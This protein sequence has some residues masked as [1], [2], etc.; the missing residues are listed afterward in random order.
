[1]T[2]PVSITELIVVLR[3]IACTQSCFTVRHAAFNRDRVYFC[4][5]GCCHDRAVVCTVRAEQLF[6]RIGGQ[7]NKII[8]QLTKSRTTKNP[9]CKKRRPLSEDCFCKYHCCGDC[10]A[11]LLGLKPPEEHAGSDRC[12]ITRALTLHQIRKSLNEE[13]KN[14]A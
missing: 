14:N 12:R 13:E 10:A 2:L 7:C 9:C 11:K 4:V 8:P 6:L 1:M 3:I 5:S